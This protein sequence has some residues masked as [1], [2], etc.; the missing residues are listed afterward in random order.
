MYKPLPKGLIIG[1][2]K[3][4]GQGLFSTEFIEPYTDLGVSHIYLMDRLIRTP[5]GG[6]VNHSDDSNCVLEDSALSKDAG[7]MCKRLVTTR[8]IHPGDELTTTYQFYKI[9][10][11]T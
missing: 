10:E 1:Q 5:L 8:T 2:S 9:H 4:D 11:P 6:F 7:F 3:I